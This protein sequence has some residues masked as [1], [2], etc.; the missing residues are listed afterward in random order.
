M[1]HYNEFLSDKNIVEHEKTI[2]DLVQLG[3]DYKDCFTRYHLNIKEKIH[4]FNYMKR[5]NKD[6][7][8]NENT[9]ACSFN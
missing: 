4:E 6:H 1:E 5:N 9:K 7:L 2:D 8:L 3:K